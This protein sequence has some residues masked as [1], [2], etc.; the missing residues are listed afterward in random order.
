MRGIVGGYYRILGGLVKGR[1]KFEV[2]I[3][4]ECK[5]VGNGNPLE[6][7][8]MIAEVSPEKDKK[9]V[10]VFN[11]PQAAFNVPVGEVFEIVD[12]ENRKRFFRS[13]LTEFKVVEGA[14]AIEGAVRWN[15]DNDVAVFDA[16][17][18]FPPK[19]EL[20]VVVRL[21]FEERIAG[22]WKT[23]VF[24]G[25]NVEEISE[26]NFTTG[27]APDYIP[28]SNV[29]HAYPITGQYNFYPKEYAQGFIELKRGQPY[30]FNPGEEWRQTIYMTESD[31]KNYAETSL[32]YNAS[33]KKVLFPIPQ[34]LND[35]VYKLEILNLPKQQAVLDANVQN[36]E[37]ELVPASDG[38]D[39]TLTTKEIEGD[40]AIREAKSLYGT[41]F[42]T[43][44][45]NTFHDKMRALTISP[46][47]SANPGNNVTIIGAYWRGSEYFDGAELGSDVNLQA[48][49]CIQIEAVLD[50]NNWYEK[51]IYPLIYEG[52]PLAGMT[53]RN[54][55]VMVLGQPPVKNML[56]TQD[57]TDLR[58]SDDGEKPDPA[59][60][61]AGS[62]MEYRVPFTMFDDYYDLQ[63]QAANYAVNHPGL[64]TQ[65]LADLLINPYPII[66]YGKYKVKLTYKIPGTDITT[67]TH[68]VELNYGR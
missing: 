45:Y 42:K 44:K 24:E 58:I 20:K 6:G 19:K 57:K 17:D 37:T 8:N 22:V 31:G 51:A 60:Y 61:Y 7:I 47:L 23:V 49:K 21:T 13:Q 35:K 25:K 10:D 14:S 54:R 27:E 46:A 50:G 28:A 30:L 36:V 2:T 33:E 59:D 39:A 65:R 53:I 34:L 52:Y 41:F 62:R 67:S 26:T 38:G 16:R 9:D 66:D 40:L 55:D 32:S 56:I 3:G 29:A 1:C 43:S 48:P 11:A 5:I 15:E 18:V 12:I 63:R 4:K 68:E 64:L